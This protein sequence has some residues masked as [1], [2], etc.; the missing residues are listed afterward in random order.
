MAIFNL[1]TY[2]LII[3][4]GLALGSFLNVVIARFDD[5]SSIIKTRSR[6]PKCQ[7]EIPWYDLIPFFSFIILS[8]RCRACKKNISLQYPLVELTT[9]IIFALIYWKF[10]ISVEALFLVFIS[11][12]L[13]I[14]AA[15]DILH[16]EIPDILSYL[17]IFFAI[18]LAL[19]NLWQ[20]GTIG[21]FDAWSSYGYSLAMGLG[22][23]SFLVLVSREKWM[24]WGDVILAGFL[25]IFL[26]FPHI[27]L[28]LFLAFV[29]GALVS[30]F[31]MMIKQKTLKDTIPFGPFLISAGFITL[32]WGQELIEFYLGKFGM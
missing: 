11:S 20:K 7:K 2:L 24:G 17:A 30:L 1:L 8:G 3:L 22:F 10:G 19:F 28:G 32:F 5:W 21:H 15:Y 25:G 4:F 29:L 9:A 23:F 13:I 16:S 12:I 31:L 18:A 27:L 14:I 26:G 6:C